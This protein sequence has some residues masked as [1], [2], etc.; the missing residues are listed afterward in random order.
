M[1]FGAGD[2]D[3][4]RG[5]VEGRYQKAYEERINPFGDFRDKEKAARKQKM[6]VADRVMYEFGQ[7]ISGSQ[8]AALLRPLRLPSFLARHCQSKPCEN[9]AGSPL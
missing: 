7:I 6:H 2:T 5:D 4:E 1:T 9:V 3:V 8:C